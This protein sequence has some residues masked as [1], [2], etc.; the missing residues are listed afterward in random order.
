M[1]NIE[2]LFMLQD[3]AKRIKFDSKDQ[4][5]IERAEKIE[6]H[7]IEQFENIYVR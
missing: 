4:E 3:I 5:E 7:F 1:E 6:K 2:E